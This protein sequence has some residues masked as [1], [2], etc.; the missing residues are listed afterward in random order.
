M[1]KKIKFCDINQVTFILRLDPVDFK[2]QS[3]VG[4]RNNT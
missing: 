3:V 1:K 2:A 4:G